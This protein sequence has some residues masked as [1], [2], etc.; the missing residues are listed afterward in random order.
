MQL[1]LKLSKTDSGVDAIAGIGIGIAASF[2]TGQLLRRYIAEVG[3]A[4]PLVFAGVPLLLGAVVI[5]A[6]LLPVIGAIRADP[7]AAP[8]WE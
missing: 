3:P 4:E 7:M 5:A 1:F 6:T 8:R 2:L